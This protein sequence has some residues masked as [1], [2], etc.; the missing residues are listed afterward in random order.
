ML[1]GGYVLGGLDAAD[2]RTAEDHLLHCPECCAELVEFAT[3]SGLLRHWSTEELR[4]VRPTRDCLPSSAQRWGDFPCPPAVAM[5]HAR[6]RDPRVV[7]AA[8]GVGAA[9]VV[10]VGV[11]SRR[12][13]GLGRG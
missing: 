4:R 11:L 1:L 12:G 3:L 13:Q 10:A 7:L 2:R 6:W 9:V 5:R 8:A